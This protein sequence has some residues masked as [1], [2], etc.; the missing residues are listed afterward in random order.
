MDNEKYCILQDLEI[1]RNSFGSE[2]SDA[3]SSVNVYIDH[4]NSYYRP[5]I[6][7]LHQVF[8]LSNQAMPYSIHTPNANKQRKV[9]QG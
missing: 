3:T 1:Y 6:S 5:S 2:K 4:S 9:M 8:E 7:S